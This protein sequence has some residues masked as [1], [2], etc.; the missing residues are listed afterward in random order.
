MGTLCLCCQPEPL[1]DDQVPGEDVPFGSPLG[2]DL[3]GA[4]PWLHSPGLRVAPY[5]ILIRSKELT[6]ASGPSSWTVVGSEGEGLTA[7]SRPRIDQEP[8]ERGASS[9][10]NPRQPIRIPR[11]APDS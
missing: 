5:G 10:R 4:C 8:A 11:G 3:C 1:I 7:A 9:L 6:G 2:S